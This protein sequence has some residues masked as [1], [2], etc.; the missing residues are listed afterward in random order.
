[1]KLPGESK[2]EPN[3]Y[4]FGVPYGFILEDLRRKN[5]DKYTR[6]N[7]LRMVERNARIKRAPERW[8]EER[9]ARFDLVICFEQRVFDIVVDDIKSR[10]SAR[11]RPVHVVN[12]ETKDTHETAVLGANAALRLVQRL[13]AAPDWEDSIEAVLDELESNGQGNVLHAVLFY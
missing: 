7:M 5:E 9:Q 12:I 11:C 6:N 3:V 8:Q 1:M 10:E 2:D 13:Y 4:E